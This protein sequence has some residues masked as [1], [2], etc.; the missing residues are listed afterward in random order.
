MPP[1]RLAEE[2][3]L[4]ESRFSSSERELAALRIDRA[5]RTER[6]TAAR[7]RGGRRGDRR[8]SRARGDAPPCVM[9]PRGGGGGGRR[10]VRHDMS[11]R[12]ELPLLDGLW[13]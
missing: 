5:A 9:W 3:G 1:S 11:V 12:V 6:E 4:L 7:R 10:P 13:R 8:E 2:R